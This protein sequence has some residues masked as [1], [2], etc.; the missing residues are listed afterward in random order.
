VQGGKKRN[1]LLASPG[2]MLTGWAKGLREFTIAPASPLRGAA[3]P[4]PTVDKDFFS[5]SRDNTKSDIG[6][7]NLTAR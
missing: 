4:V 5:K 7:F 2:L 3:Q 6:P 1:N